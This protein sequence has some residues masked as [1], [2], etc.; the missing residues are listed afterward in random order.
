MAPQATQRDFSRRGLLGS[1]VAVAAAAATGTLGGGTAF[2]ASGVTSGVT[3]APAGVTSVPAGG[4]SQLSPL[5]REFTAAPFTHPQIPFIGRA[6]YRGGSALP[7]P[8]PA[9][10]SPPTSCT[11]APGRTTPRTPPLRSTEPSPLP[12]SAAAAR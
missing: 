5:W 8:V 6:G 7:R 3:S 12:E 9:T 1:A 4:R 2:A 10:A 11:T